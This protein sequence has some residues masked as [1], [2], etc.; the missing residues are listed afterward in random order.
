MSKTRFVT[1][2]TTLAKPSQ[3]NRLA[4]KIVDS[5]LAACAQLWPLHSIYRWQGKTESASETALVCK[6][7]ARLAPVLVE[8]IRSLHPYEVPEV[9]VTPILD[10]L[11]AYLAW[12]EQETSPGQPRLT[13]PPLPTKK[14][15][16]KKS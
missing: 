9:V 16:S 4:R 15:P 3:A 14:S 6:T 7:R 10:G 13:F 1:V 2:T 5:R 12:I 8:F 11:P